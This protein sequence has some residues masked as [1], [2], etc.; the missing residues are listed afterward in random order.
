M[1][2]RTNYAQSQQRALG[3][4]VPNGYVVERYELDVVQIKER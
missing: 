4:V 3:I 2:E 1:R